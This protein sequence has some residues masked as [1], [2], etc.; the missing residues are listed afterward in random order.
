MNMTNN[1][2]ICTLC[3]QNKLISEFTKHKQK[4]DGLNSWCKVC[5][6]KKNK[7]L[8]QSKEYKRKKSEYDKK[9][10]QENKAK[11]D[12]ASKKRREQNKDK[13]AEYDKEYRKQLGEKRLA[14]KRDYYHNRGGK[15]LNRKWNLVNKD[16]VKANDHNIRAKRREQASSSLLTAM[17]IKNWVDSQSKLCSY[18]GIICSENYQ[19]DHIEPLA[20]GGLHELSNFAISC[21][22]CNQSKGPKP[23]LV[24]F[25]KKHYSATNRSE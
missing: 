11:L 7:K 20:L 18:C 10:R 2:K 4:K 13:K 17:D 5:S 9:Y 16:K 1:M 14:N 19:I 12:K 3:K 25:A 15:E 24:W 22:T 6:R 8:T 21:P 23:L